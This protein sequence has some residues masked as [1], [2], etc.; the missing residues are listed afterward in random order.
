M[1]KSKCIECNKQ[2]NYWGGK[3]CR[4][5]WNKYGF[6]SNTSHW[7]GGKPKCMDCEI[8]ISYYKK[9]CKSCNGKWIYK[10]GGG[11]GTWTKHNYTSQNNHAWKGDN[12]GYTALHEW[13]RKRLNRERCYHCD[14][15]KRK[16][17]A[18]NKSGNYRRNLNDWI[19]LCNPCHTKY[20][21][22]KR[23]NEIFTK[24]FLLGIG[25]QKLF[26]NN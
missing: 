15:N 6:G 25:V 24:G 7:K 12:V 21:T 4:D 16:I 19:P 5:C 20:D 17:Y 13:V 9:R 18:A 10:N 8:Q 3:R 14:T 1:A 23:E 11:L 26:I 2:L 22:Q